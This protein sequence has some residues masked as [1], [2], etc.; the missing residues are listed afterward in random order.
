MRL[1][2]FIALLAAITVGV[3]RFYLTQKVRM[4]GGNGIYT[5][6][7]FVRKVLKWLEDKQGAQQ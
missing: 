2:S 3:M 6:L 5:F 1:M 7:G 4:T